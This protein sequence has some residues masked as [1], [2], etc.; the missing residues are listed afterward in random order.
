MLG[1]VEK[2]WKDPQIKIA[3]HLCSRGI[4]GGQRFLYEVRPDIFPQGFL[5]QTETELW[6]L[7]YQELSEEQKQNG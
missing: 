3:L 4:G 2:L 6:S 7:Y 1:G 5:T